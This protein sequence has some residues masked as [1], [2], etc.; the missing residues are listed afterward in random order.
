[1]T[2]A[3]RQALARPTG[4]TVSTTTATFVGLNEAGTLGSVLLGEDRLEF[5]VVGYYLPRPGELVRLL[6]V[7]REA[8][9]LGPATQKPAEGVVVAVRRSTDGFTVADVE[10]AGSTV[11]SGLRLFDSVTT[12]TPGDVVA[13]DWALGG[14]IVGRFSRSVL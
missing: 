1:L 11:H 6:R 14:V 4:S 7:D 9:I 10:T 2:S 8:Y 5:P 12:P 3:A 13:L